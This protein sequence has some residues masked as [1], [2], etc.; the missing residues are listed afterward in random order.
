VIFVQPDSILPIDKEW[1]APLLRYT[2][3]GRIRATR[4][5]GEW[6]MG[7]VLPIDTMR[8]MV[9]EDDWDSRGEG[10]DYSEYLGVT[11]YEPMLPKNA[12]ARGGL[13]FQIPKT[14]EERWQ[15]IRKMP[16]G[17]PVDVYL[18]IDG[19]SFTAYVVVERSEVIQAGITSRSLELRMG[20]GF[21][22]N[23][24]EAERKYNVLERLARYCVEHNVSLALRGEVY[25]KGIQAFEGNPHAQ[26]EK[27]VAFFSVYNITEH[28]YISVDEP[29]N[30]L[31]VC[32]ALY[33]PTVPLLARSVPLTQ[34]LID[35][36]D[37][38]LE[39]IKLPDQEPMPFEGVV[40]QGCGYSFKIINKHYDM[41]K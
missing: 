22:S 11:K 30:L 5:R 33:L 14:D 12:D 3:R 28:A 16:F 10:V 9:S 15:N 38:Q 24:H 18:K 40:V 32:K 41:R 34:E 25:G 8:Y 7:L 37:S 4:L 2:S 20:D 36:Y 21:N 23:W 26:M 35:R 29:H 17:D 31:E 6:S 13:P 39:T 27:D 19:Q 1:A